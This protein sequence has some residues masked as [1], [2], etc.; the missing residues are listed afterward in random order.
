MAAFPAA[1]LRRFATVF[2]NDFRYHLRRPLFIIWVLVLIFFSWGMSTGK[3]RIQSGDAAVGGTKSHV[4]SEFAV[5][6]QLSVMTTVFYGLFV[7]IASGM[8][9]I[10][11]EE[12]RVGEMLRSTPLR[13]REYVWGKFGA[14]LVGCGVVLTIHLLSMIFFNHILP[15]AD[16]AEFHGPFRLSNY[17]RPALFLSLP[18]VL[19]FSGITFCLGAITRRPLLVFLLPVAFV[20]L[21]LFFFWSWAPGWLDPR[22]DRVLMLLDPSGFRWL[23][24]TFLKVDRGVEFYN[25]SPIELDWPFLVSRIAWAFVGLSAVELARRHYAAIGRSR[26]VTERSRRR[27]RRPTAATVNEVP[28]FARMTRSAPLAALSMSSNQPGF[29]ETAWAVA[30]IELVELRSSPAL[31]LF[32]PWMLLETLGNSL[33]EVGFL[34]AALLVTPVGFAVRSMSALVTSLCLLLLVYTVESLERERATRLAAFAHALP[35]RTAALLVGK[36]VGLAIASLLI[37]A[38]VIVAGWIAILIQHK[39]PFSV[40]PFLY[41]WGLLL[42]PS[43]LLWITFVM[44]VH[45]ITQNRYT[46]Y[47]VSL[48]VLFFTAYRLFTNQINWL[49]N[50]PMWQAVRGSDISPLE[51]DRTAIILSRLFALGLAGFFTALTIRYYRRR[52]LDPTQTMHRL[53]AGALFRE[54]LRLAPWAAVPVVTAIWLGLA[55]GRGHEGGAAK[56]Q[57]KDYWRKNLATYRDA[58]IP[59]LKHVSLD[60]DLFPETGRYRASGMLEL[61]NRSD[62]PLNEILLSAPAHWEKLTW[63]LAGADHQP[64][65]RARLFVFKP[66]KGPLEPGQSVEI[67]FAHEGYFP[68]GISKRGSPRDEFIL[69]SSV[70]LTSF[71]GSMVP[72]LGFNESVGVDDENKQDPKE[73]ADDYYRG[74]TDSFVGSRAPFTTKITVTAPAEFTINS[75]GTKVADKESGGRRRVVWVSDHPVSFFN[76]VAGRW[77]VERGTGTEIYYHPDHSYN[78]TEIRQ[79]LDGARRY[80]SEWF[81]PFPWR[82]LKLSEFANMST[83]AQGFP[84][85]ITFSEGIGFLTESSPEVH[86]AFEI[87]SHEAAHQWWGNILTPGKGPGGNILSEGTAHFSTILLIEQVQGLSSR[88]SFCKRIED[89][90]NKSRHSDSERPL[91]KIDGQKP[92][93]TTVTYDKG[94]WVFWMLMNQMGRDRNLAGIRAFFKAYEG[95]EDH[96]VLQDFVAAM[97]PFAADPSAYDAFTK[98]WFFDVVV[99]EYRLTEPNRTGSGDAWQASVK[100]ENIGSGRMPVEIAVTKGDRFAKD[101]TVS[102][103]YREARTTVTLGQGE[104]TSVKIPCSF[105]PDAIIVDPDAKVLQ[106]RRK[107]AVARL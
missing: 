19:F 12:W 18:T 80:F 41:Y 67:S 96:P 49:G 103:D 101:G 93:D 7:A 42:V 94:G 107:A 98:E 60:L 30:R 100:V 21:D 68:R 2:A 72:V 64:Q 85:N 31:Y 28:E 47:A 52:E 9:V 84:T 20:L 63:K 37:A 59:D 51:L 44:A 36:A 24:Q 10:Q 55:I 22:L 23:D 106:L 16:A 91:V 33:Y 83:Y 25:N 76:V 56:K 38:A 97:R 79:A 54:A 65:D 6:M 78:I 29:F 5:A 74:Q 87:T 81:F 13:S 61:I 58:R 57:E 43:V 89:G 34:D 4:T 35:V 45:S 14:V 11:D 71:S 88:I 8:T 53:A 77:N 39:V 105:Q 104:S 40:V 75:V 99:P 90:Y 102:P 82:D 95:K 27:E 62:K 73:Y 46:T 1:S 17:I 69:P 70:V 66:E 32:V 92:G 48:V 3:V 26:L 50:W 86:S 15:N